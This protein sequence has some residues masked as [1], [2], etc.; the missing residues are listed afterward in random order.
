MKACLGNMGQDKL[1]R[2]QARGR[3]TGKERVPIQQSDQDGQDPDSMRGKGKS[4]A[5]PL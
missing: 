2:S 5:G 4:R 3:V 1:L